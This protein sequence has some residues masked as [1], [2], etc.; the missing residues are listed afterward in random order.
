MSIVRLIITFYVYVFM[1]TNHIRT[2]N[3]KR[4]RFYIKGML[5]QSFFFFF[6]TLFTLKSYE[7]KFFTVYEN[8]FSFESYF[9]QNFPICTPLSLALRVCFHFFR[10]PQPYM[11]MVFPQKS[12]ADL[13][14]HIGSWSTKCKQICR[15]R[16]GGMQI[17]IF[18]LE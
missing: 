8:N 14:V 17:G 13:K 9:T 5:S 2:F 6:D 10:S 18:I 1:R 3:V 16:D 11:D 7:K 12:E 4:T 15:G